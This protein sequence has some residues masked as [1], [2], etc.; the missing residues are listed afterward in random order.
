MACSVKGLLPRGTAGDIPKTGFKIEWRKHK[1][2]REVRVFLS[3]FTWYV[4]SDSWGFR[5][6]I[7]SCPL[8]VGNS[9]FRWL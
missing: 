8:F 9:E 7:L 5:P 3:L 4:F 2:K 1:D 6:R